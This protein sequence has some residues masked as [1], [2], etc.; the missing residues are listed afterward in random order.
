MSNVNRRF[1]HACFEKFR[2]EK[3]GLTAPTASPG[4]WLAQGVAI[5]TVVLIS[6]TGC[7]AFQDV[8]LSTDRLESAPESDETKACD[9]AMP[10]YCNR[11]KVRNVCTNGVWQQQPKCTTAVCVDALG[12]VECEPGKHYCD[13]SVLHVCDASGKY[14]IEKDCAAE[15]TEQ[16]CDT[17][18][19]KCVVCKTGSQ[20]CDGTEALLSCIDGFYGSRLPCTDTVIGCMAVDGA[21]DYCSECTPAGQIT[22]RA[23]DI[24][25]CD[26]TLRWKL[27]EDCGTGRCETNGADVSCAPAAAQ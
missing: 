22:C 20:R 19:N 5:W 16:I 3:L 12:C 15:A 7:M 9:A 1:R 21:T 4:P 23:G 8:E 26:T 2:F 24:R 18:L 25:Q 14:V 27:L 17:I 13:G 10:A 11:D 6:T